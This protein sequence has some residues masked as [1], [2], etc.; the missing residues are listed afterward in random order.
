MNV[1]VGRRYIWNLG[2]SLENELGKGYL[3]R[4]EK[5]DIL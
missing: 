5:L 2:Y 1:K 4:K 3:E